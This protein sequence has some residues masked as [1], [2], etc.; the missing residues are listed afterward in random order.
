MF[1]Y[2]L[3]PETFGYTRSYFSFVHLVRYVDTKC[4]QVCDILLRFLRAW[5]FTLRHIATFLPLRIN[6]NDSMQ[7]NYQPFCPLKQTINLEC[8][9]FK[10]EHGSFVSPS[11]FNG[12]DDMK[13]SCTTR[14]LL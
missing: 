8:T 7:Q 5:A 9:K 6:V 4:R 14:L 12:R 11:I 10:S 1:R 13:D 2:R 3:S